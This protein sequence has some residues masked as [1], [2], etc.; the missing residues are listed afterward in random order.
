MP[1][2][3][4]GPHLLQRTEANMYSRVQ[5]TSR[6]SQALLLTLGLSHQNK[7]LI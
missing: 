3:W 6:L 2:A 4:Q 1:Q 5:P 7:H